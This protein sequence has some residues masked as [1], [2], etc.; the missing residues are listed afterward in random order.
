MEPPPI[1]IDS[2]KGRYA[3]HSVTPWRQLYR[4]CWRLHSETLLIQ[5]GDGCGLLME[6]VELQFGEAL[7]ER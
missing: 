2:S 3:R 7:V 6:S 1:A 5:F 4:D